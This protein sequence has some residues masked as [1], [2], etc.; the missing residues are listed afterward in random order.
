MA[1]PVQII[2]YAAGHAAAC[3]ALQRHASGAG[4]AGDAAG[5][6]C[7]GLGGRGRSQRFAL[8]AR[9]GPRALSP[10]SAL[11]PPPMLDAVAAA[12][13]PPALRAGLAG[14]WHP[15]AMNRQDFRL[16][17]CAQ[18]SDHQSSAKVVLP[19]PLG[20]ATIQPG[21]S[22]RRSDVFASA[23]SAR[24]SA[25]ASRATSAFGLAATLRN[26]RMSSSTVTDTAPGGMCANR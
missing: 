5:Q 13:R 10:A 11:A 14:M 2:D 8:S 22:H 4:P 9:S 23:S 15:Y 1:M 20:P 6:P 3:A 24:A 7:A 17:N 18:R 21:R 12:C 19:A 25:P 26:Q 16:V